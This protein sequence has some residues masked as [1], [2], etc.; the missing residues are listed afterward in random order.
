MSG[1]S[2]TA[3]ALTYSPAHRTLFMLHS[4]GPD[5]IR[6]M[7]VDED[8]MLI[9]RLEGYTVN[10]ADKPNRVATM[11]ALTADEKFL[12]VGTTFDEPAH[13]NPDGSPILWVQK[14]GAPHSIA[15]NAPDPTA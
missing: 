5:H 10:T 2:G 6:L 7:S 4:F 11:A 12:L 9:P 15:S 13:A 14:D 3:K 8:G 1:R